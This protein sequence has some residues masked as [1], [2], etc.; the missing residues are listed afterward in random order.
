MTG[1]YSL[2]I[3]GGAGPKKGGDYSAT[4]IHLCELTTAGRKMLADGLSALDVV[5]EMVWQ[6]EK[7][8]MYVAGR[9]SGPNRAG[10]AELDASIM[11]SRGNAGGVTCI[12]N[13]RSPIA[14]ARS[15]MDNTPYILLAG[16]GAKQHALSQGLSFVD[17]NEDWYTLPVGVSAE[18]MQQEH[19]IHGTVG[20]VAMDKSG[21]L[22]SATSTGGLFGKPEGRVGDTG[23]IGAGSWA[24]ENIAISCTGV[25]EYF[26]LAGG[27]R[28]IADRMT[29]GGMS[30]SAAV[31]S[32]LDEV[33]AR[34]GDGGIIAVT[35]S[36][37]IYSAY[38]S[39][40]MKEAR[41]DQDTAP[42]STT[43]ATK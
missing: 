20:A 30:V 41:T 34:G 28:S 22:A 40:G 38:N 31:Q 1:N 24:D 11:D 37:E 12:K 3:H 5:Q 13:V 25:G 4:E 36:G 8:G 43:F 14:A 39:D 26:I 23:L 6:M 17:D 33:E 9:G 16:E 27:A 2:I 32:F 35:K 15:V 18:D 7:S 29:F 42:I 19:M 10:Y 21:V